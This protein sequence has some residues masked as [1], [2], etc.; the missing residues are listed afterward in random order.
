MEVWNPLSRL[1]HMRVLLSKESSDWFIDQPNVLILGEGL[2]VVN[3]DTAALIEFIDIASNSIGIRPDPAL[4]A[5]QIRLRQGVIDT[6]AE[7][8]ALSGSLEKGGNTATTFA[9]GDA[10]AWQLINP[11]GATTARKLDW[12][13]DVKARLAEDLNAGFAA[14]VPKMAFDN[15][16]GARWGWWRIDPVSG[17]TIGVMD[18]GLHTAT[19]DKMTLEQKQAYHEANFARRA[20]INRNSNN[21]LPLNKADREIRQN[22]LD[23]EKALREAGIPYKKGPV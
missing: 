21:T 7:Q 13:G 15:G 1:A 23:I 6:I 18:T 22:M 8:V 14:Y 17:E 20:Q 9:P 4:N 5:F 12:P 10:D 3:A 11:R 19:T 16:G 2:P